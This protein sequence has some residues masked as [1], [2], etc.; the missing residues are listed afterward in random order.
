[1]AGKRWTS[2]E[3]NRLRLLVIKEERRSK[4][5]G[6]KFNWSRVANDLNSEFSTNKSESQIF[7]YHQRMKR[8]DKAKADTRDKMISRYPRPKKDPYEPKLLRVS[9]N[10]ES[11][12]AIIIKKDGITIKRYHIN[13]SEENVIESISKSVLRMKNET[14]K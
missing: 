10:D 6:I 12:F 14:P 5:S 13:N 9:A 2:K 4:E 8:E 11:D 3:T 1:M 7:W